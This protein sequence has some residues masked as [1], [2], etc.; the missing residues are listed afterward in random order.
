MRDLFFSRH[1]GFLLSFIL[2]FSFWLRVCISVQ[3]VFIFRLLECTSV[4]LE[5]KSANIFFR[6]VCFILIFFS[7]FVGYKISEK[8]HVIY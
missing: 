6:F 7:K 4:W 8:Q 2:C 5:C 1:A 3:G